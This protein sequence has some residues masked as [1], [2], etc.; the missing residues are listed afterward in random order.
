MQKNARVSESKT[1]KVES[2]APGACDITV[3]GAATPIR[4]FSLIQLSKRSQKNSGL[5]VSLRN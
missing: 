1:K 5:L 2:L 3:A 4:A